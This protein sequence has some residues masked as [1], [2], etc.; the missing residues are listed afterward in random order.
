MLTP[1]VPALRETQA[2]L[3]GRQSSR[4]FINRCRSSRPWPGEING[5]HTASTKPFSQFNSTKHERQRRRV[6]QV[7]LGRPR[8]CRLQGGRLQ[9]PGI[10]MGG[11][12]HRI[13]RCRTLGSSEP[14]KDLPRSNGNERVLNGPQQLLSVTV[15][16]TSRI[17]RTT[18]WLFRT[19]LSAESGQ[20]KGDA[21]RFF[22]G[23]RRT[24]VTELG[25]PSRP[26]VATV[27]GGDGRSVYACR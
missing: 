13:T 24:M 12:V 10:F 20:R 15:R 6:S 21:A 22:V 7:R 16:L 2:T 3:A 23:L 27:P 18:P 17:T 5:P 26:L 11:I 8:L 19:R 25:G 1:I 9:R 4:R 14:Q